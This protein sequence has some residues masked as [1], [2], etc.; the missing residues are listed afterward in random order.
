MILSEFGLPAP[1]NRAV[2]VRQLSSTGRVTI[3]DISSGRY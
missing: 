1:A 3:K 2:I